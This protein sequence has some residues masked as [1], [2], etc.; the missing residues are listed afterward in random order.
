MP[1]SRGE[2]GNRFSHK[3]LHRA[4]MTKSRHA[5]PR[6]KHGTGRKHRKNSRVS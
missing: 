1:Y 5:P 2:E 6:V 3:A 4:T